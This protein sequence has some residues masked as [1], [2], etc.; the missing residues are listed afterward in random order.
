MEVTASERKFGNYIYEYM[1]NPASLRKDTASDSLLQSFFRTLSQCALNVRG[2]TFQITTLAFLQDL[3]IVIRTPIRIHIGA[4]SLYNVP[5]RY[6]QNLCRKIIQIQFNIWK[7][8]FKVLKTYG[9]D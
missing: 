8:I 5:D 6:Y 4:G 7:I 2:S 1:S 9:T 3:K